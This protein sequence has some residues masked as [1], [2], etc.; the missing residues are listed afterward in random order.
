MP[1]RKTS[2]RRAGVEIIDE[3]EIRAKLRYLTVSFEKK[4]GENGPI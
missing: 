3:L 2:H 4:K 1:H